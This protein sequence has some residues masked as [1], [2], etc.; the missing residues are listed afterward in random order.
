MLFVNVLLDN[1]P[2]GST[3]VFKIKAQLRINTSSKVQ[4]LTWPD[5][6]WKMHQKTLKKL[7]DLIITD[8]AY[9]DDTVTRSAQV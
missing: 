6:K 5:R 2:S 7:K 4:G 3:Q 8:E 1:Q 9:C